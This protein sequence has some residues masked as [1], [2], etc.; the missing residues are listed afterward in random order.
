[1]NDNRNSINNIS[2]TAENITINRNNPNSDTNTINMVNC[3]TIPNE[4]AANP[5]DTT[6]QAATTHAPQTTNNSNNTDNE[7]FVASNVFSDADEAD[8]DDDEEEDVIDG[9]EIEKEMHQNMR[10]HQHAQ[11]VATYQR[12]KSALTGREVIVSVPGHHVTT[13]TVVNDIKVSEVQIL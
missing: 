10:N 11:R 8:P 4:E 5:N 2:T 12:E 6:P 1:M 13:W 3:R 7:T 9:L